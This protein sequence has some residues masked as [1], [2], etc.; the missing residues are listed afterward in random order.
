MRSLRSFAATLCFFAAIVAHAAITVATYN[1]ENYLVADRMVDGV[2]R[3]A[4]PKPESEKTAVRK[5]IVAIAPDIIALQ[6]I[7]TPPFL[8]ELQRDLKTDGAD[9]PHALVLDAAD[10]DRHVAVLSKLPFKAVRKHAAVPVTF[11]DKKD[12]VKRGVLEVTF[13]TDAGDLTL[14]IVHLKSKRTE[15]PDDIEGTAQRQAE[16]EAVRDLALARFPEPAKAMFMI[17]GDW[18]DTRN[19]KPVKTLLKRGAT[20]LGT[21]VETMD[22]R[23]EGWTHFY[24]AANTYSQID[25]LLVSPALRPFVTSG[26]GNI[27]DGV[28]VLDGSDHR[29]VSLKLNLN[30]AK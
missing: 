6:E 12:V 27:Y 26:R 19:N 11:L 14:F 23:G 30:P 17:C 9:Y 7:G 22:S 28:G 29:P 4:Y 13:A 1:I 10:P 8:A 20:E 5:A 25:Y 21:I 2:Y 18:N 15:H 16:A 24:R 3:A